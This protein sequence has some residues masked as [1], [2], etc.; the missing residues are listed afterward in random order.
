MTDI[1]SMFEYLRLQLI[2]AVITCRVDSNKRAVHAVRTRTRRLEALL[3]KVLEDHPG[4]AGLHHEARKTL[5]QLKRIRKM[6]GP[7]RDLN[8]HRKLA[9]ELKDK[10]LSHKSA[11]FREHLLR[12][13]KRLDHQLRQNCRQR[14]IVLRKGLMKFE[15]S[16]ERALERTGNKIAGLTADFPTPLS[17]ARRW[18]RRSSFQLGWLNEENLHEYRKQTK[19]ARYVAE[20]QETSRAAQHLA[21]QLNH[22][23]EAIGKWHDWKLL[24][25]RAKD[26][27]GK[28]AP[29]VVVLTKKRDR[30]LNSA[31]RIAIA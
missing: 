20:L 21:K 9:K 19:A 25:Q 28:D 24:L 14:A 7:V 6:A 3:R 1:S 12:E 4:A 8:V 5:R 29:A 15:L 10:M 30:A 22:L 26:C 17:T 18:V 16:L 27:L 13:Y 23:Q 2:Q 31:L 11:A